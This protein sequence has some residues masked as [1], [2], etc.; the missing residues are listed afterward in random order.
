MKLFQIIAS[1]QGSRAFS[2]MGQAFGF[3][4]ELMAQTVRYFIPPMA[5][6]ID[7]GPRRPRGCWRSWSSWVRGATT[8]F[9][10]IHAFSGMRRC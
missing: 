4:D 9:S 6:A 5:K 1:A 3:T 7:R 8:A 2:N 10:T